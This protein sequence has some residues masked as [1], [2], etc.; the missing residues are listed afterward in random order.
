[1]QGVPPALHGHTPD[2]ALRFNRN[3]A[4]A[5]LGEAGVRLQGPLEVAA[6][7]SWAYLLEPTLTT[8][9]ELLG[10]EVRLRPWRAEDVASLPKPWELAPV[11]V[12]G[13]L[14]GY[15]DPE[16]CSG[17]CCTGTRSRTK[18]GSPIP[19]STTWWTGPGGR[20]T[21]GSAWNCST[22][23]TAWRWRSWQR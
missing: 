17:C 5:L 14:P 6:Q 22:G 11:Y 8:W 10:V 3:Q 9:R 12:A 16:Y 18:V 4:H 21:A 15:P 2:I 1:M 23:R 7:D 19:R 20:A 13:W